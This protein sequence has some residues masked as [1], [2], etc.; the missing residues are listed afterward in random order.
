MRRVVSLSLPT[1]PT[2][3]LRRTAGT[4]A[5]PPGEPLV[6]SGRDGQQRVITSADAT[7]LRLGLYPGLP[8]AQARARVPRLHIVDADPA[9]DADALE[10]LAQWCIRYS[11][12]V[13]T[14][15]P[16]GIWIDAT[17][18][19]H[20]FGGEGALLSEIAGRLRK[21]GCV[22]RAALAD[23]A[24]AAHA[25]ARYG[26]KRTIAVETGGVTAAIW[27]LPISALRLSANLESD[28]RRLGFESIGNLESTPRAPLALRF[29]SEVGRRLDQAFGRQA[30][31]L[32]PIVLKDLASAT[33]AFVEPIG[34]P[35]SFSLAITHLV[36]ELC[37]ALEVRN[38]GARRLNL[39]FYRV[40]GI[41]Q[42]IRIGTS[43]P[44]RD[45]KRLAR[46]LADHLETIDPGFGI[47]RMTLTASLSEP[48]TLRQVGSFGSDD[49]AG[50]VA[51]LVD[52]LTNRLGS[53]KLF[54]LAPIE[55]DV[56]ER[57][58]RRVP[59]MSRPTG[60]TWPASLPRPSRLLRRPEEVE[61]MALLPDHPPAFFVWRGVRRRITRADGPERIFGEWW[62]ADAE[63]SA[64][65]DYFQVEDEAGERFWLFRSGDGVD[66]KAGS[67]RWYVHGVFA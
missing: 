41:V 32:D 28:L 60:E 63:V 4:A 35:A 20:L 19:A 15:P 7:A 37:P 1:W 33:R 27:S 62:R 42:A 22:A 10:R 64:V 61:T 54:R 2:D 11:P 67:L 9:A 18:V 44:N 24:G 45:A 6:L 30:E 55:S 51:A 14:D 66:P 3:R 21:S 57:S 50:D 39:L 49:K 31:P 58:H 26:H 8:V 13:A 65:R 36:D 59:P 34:A 38:L 29:G 16:D 56:P 47:E 25:L 48:L 40:D 43:K 5:P 53:D 46:L 23:T 52:T 12:I 17:G